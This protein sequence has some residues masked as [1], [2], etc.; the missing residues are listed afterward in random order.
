MRPG[1]AAFWLTV[2]AI[3]GLISWVK[4]GIPKLEARQ[5]A[6]KYLEARARFEATKAQQSDRLK[7]IAGRTQ[8]TGAPINRRKGGR[9]VA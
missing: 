9:D 7:N 2:S 8:R 3:V 6:K 1:L 4:W 5:D